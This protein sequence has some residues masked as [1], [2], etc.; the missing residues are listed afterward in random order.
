MAMPDLVSSQVIPVDDEIRVSGLS[1]RRVTRPTAEDDDFVAPR[2]PSRWGAVGVVLLAAA[3]ASG[4]I[5]A[6]AW[7]MHLLPHQREAARRA[8]NVATLLRR[9][10]DAMTAQRFARSPN[11]YSVEDF[12]DDVFAIEPNNPRAVQLRRVA[13]ARLA[14][15]ATTAR[16]NH[17]PEQA[18][19]MLEGA[20]RLADDPATR[21]DLAAARRE[22]DE[23]RAHPAATPTPRPRPVVRPA[24]PAA[25]A[26]AP[27][28]PATP[29]AAAPANTAAA[30]RTASRGRIATPAA[31]P[32]PAPGVTFTPGRDASSDPNTSVIPTP[33]GP[34]QLTLPSSSPPDP[35]TP[36]PPAPST[37]PPATTPPTAEF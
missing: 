10:G 22:L 16:N 27:A 9:A 33:F 34:V 12:T 21:Q 7:G 4:V 31:T 37:N 17:H 18:I 14:D 30:R 20:L 28:A 6:G 1:P 26:P 3:L 24:A 5:A 13:A 29:P 36:T 32:D 19:P 25:P 2:R 35:P 8:E 15:A 23:Q 11:H